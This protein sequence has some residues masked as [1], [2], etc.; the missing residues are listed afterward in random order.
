MH[1]KQFRF[2]KKIKYLKGYED[3]VFFACDVSNNLYWFNYP[4]L[5]YKKLLTTRYPSTY[6]SS[7]HIDCDE[8]KNNIVCI[9]GQLKK[10]GRFHW[11]KPQE[12]MIYSWHLSEI[13]VVKLSPDGQYLCSGDIEGYS[14]LWNTSTGNVVAILPRHQDYVSAICFDHAGRHVAVGS[15]DKSITITNLITMQGRNKIQGFTYAIAEVFFLSSSTIICVEKRDFVTIWDFIEG[16]EIGKFTFDGAFITSAS[17]STDKE[18][19]FIGT[20]NQGIKVIDLL[21]T[22][23]L[24]FESVKNIKDPISSLC[25]LSQAKTIVYATDDRKFGFLSL[26]DD[27]TRITLEL[28]HALSLRHYLKAYKLFLSHPFLRQTPLFATYN[29]EWDVTLYKAEDLL[30]EGDIEQARELLHLFYAVPDKQPIIKQILGEYRKFPQFKRAYNEKNIPVLYSLASS[31]PLLKHSHF[32]KEIEEKWNKGLLTISHLALTSTKNI[33]DHILAVISPFQGT[34]EKMDVFHLLIKQFDIFMAYQQA[35]LKKDFKHFFTYTDT[36]PALRK[37]PEYTQAISV[38]EGFIAT[39]HTLIKNEKFEEARRYINTIKLFPM[40]YNKGV[41]IEDSI[42][43]ALEFQRNV[44]NKEYTKVYDLLQSHPDLGKL[45]SFIELEQDIEYHFRKCEVFVSKGEIE[46]ITSIVKDFYSIPLFFEKI[47]S[48]YT[49]AYSTQFMFELAM[50]NATSQTLNSSISHY[51]SIFGL[52]DTITL[53]IE[54]IRRRTG[55]NVTTQGIKPRHD[56]IDF[57][58]IKLPDFII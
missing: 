37:F 48:F 4:D 54:H 7:H 5:K 35:F 8:T 31:F 19:L 1:N 27:L 45:H 6:D 34:K 24:E 15:Y 29:E 39:T 46:N 50:G 58:S 33:K 23:E 17:L 12:T 22:V 16:V 10:I 49:A 13:E 28:E 53:V 26:L 3:N 41:E 14:Y 25:Y 11:D 40:L 56:Y 43:L 18:Y 30:E 42:T 2:P 52:D 20:S 36:Y 44:L 55:F 47:R 21:E 38:G 9:H 32:F 57:S 51:I